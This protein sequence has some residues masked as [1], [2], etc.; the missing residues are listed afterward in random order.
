[1]RFSNL[2]PNILRQTLIKG[3]FQGLLIWSILRDRM[4]LVKYLLVK[5]RMSIPTSLA[6]A[7]M[8]DTV[9]KKTAPDTDTKSDYKDYQIEYENYA[10]EIF[11][12]LWDSNWESTE[13]ILGWPQKEWA[14]MTALDFAEVAS[15]HRFLALPGMVSVSHKASRWTIG[16]Q[17]VSFICNH[18]LAGVCMYV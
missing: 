18:M 2:I 13:K 16:H 10:V 3:A 7:S 6:I 5:S 17:S 14:N 11:S 12:K 8:C 9:R 1:M 15:A 4:D